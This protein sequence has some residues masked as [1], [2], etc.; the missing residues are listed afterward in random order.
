MQHS[1]TAFPVFINSSSQAKFT[2]YSVQ[3]LPSSVVFTAQLTIFS[4]PNSGL[5]CR[6]NSIIT[7]QTLCGK[8]NSKNK[9]SWLPKVALH[10]RHSTSLHTPHISNLALVS[11]LSFVVNQHIKVWLGI[12]SGKVSD[13]FPSWSTRVAAI[14]MHPNHLV[15]V[16]NNYLRKLILYTYKVVR[17]SRQPRPGMVAN[18][19][20]EPSICSAGSM[21]HHMMFI[22]QVQRTI[23]L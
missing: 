22:L 23:L 19:W 13:L 6:L 5:H 17:P 1:V 10:N 15:W 18:D 7:F 11:N 9:W 20:G 3:A 2:N 14:C 21:T 4:Q 12:I 16:P 8:G